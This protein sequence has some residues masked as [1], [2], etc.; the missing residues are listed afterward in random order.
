MRQGRSKP[1]PQKIAPE[2]CAAPA[3]PQRPLGD[4]GVVMMCAGF[5]SSLAELVAGLPQSIAEAEPELLPRLT[6]ML[7][8]A[9]ARPKQE[10]ASSVFE[11][12]PL[13]AS[14]PHVC[15]LSP[16]GYWSDPRTIGALNL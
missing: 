15:P 6:A 9:Q 10:G 13:S 11:L 14:R 1:P 7:D 16:P 4:L 12:A 8:V 3:S 2:A 5:G